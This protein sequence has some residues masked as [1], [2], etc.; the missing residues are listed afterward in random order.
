MSSFIS[1]GPRAIA[2]SSAPS[3]RPEPLPLSGEVTLFAYLGAFQLLFIEMGILEAGVKGRL[4]EEGV[5]PP[6]SASAPRRLK[7]GRG[8]RETERSPPAPRVKA[9]TRKSGI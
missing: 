1:G 7:P 2:G 9:G 6:T 5:S 3:P 8:T 4:S